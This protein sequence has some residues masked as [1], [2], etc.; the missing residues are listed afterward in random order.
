MSGSVKPCQRCGRHFARKEKYSASQWE[1]ASFCSRQCAATKRTVPD[2][3]IV[4]IY[5]HGSSSGEIGEMFGLSG[6]HVLRILK[7]NG[8]SLRP[9][10]EGMKISHAR[11]SVKKKL[12][13]A[14]TGR[15]HSEQSKDKLRTLIGPKKHGWRSGL[16]MVG[17]YLQFTSSPANGT[18]AG[19]FLHTV[20]AE[21][22]IGRA[23]LPGEVVHHE[24]RNKLNNDPSNIEVM[25]ASEHAKLHIAAGEFVRKRKIA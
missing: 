13:K 20:I 23:L 8:V 6:T 24:D 9:A 18:H 7:A 16:T 1:K 12:S 2:R 17:G 10:S 3:E 5:N 15:T 21:W 25:T 11:E 14:A 19:K 22:K 4:S